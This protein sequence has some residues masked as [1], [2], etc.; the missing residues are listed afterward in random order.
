MSDIFL[1]ARHEPGLRKGGTV[2]SLLGDVATATRIAKAAKACHL[3]VHNFDRSEGLKDHFSRKPPVLILID[4]DSKEAEAYRLLKEMAKN[5]DF[6]RV[7]K[8]G[9]VS[10]TKESLKREAQAAG[11]DRVYSRTEFMKE[12]NNIFMRYAL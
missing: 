12:L 5:A 3:E 1:D 9:F 6:K 8:V 11:C 2:F 10:Q 7:P 4:W